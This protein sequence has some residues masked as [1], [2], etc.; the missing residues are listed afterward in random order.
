MSM[1]TALQV[2]TASN[3]WEP[4]RR[5]TL[6]SARRRSVV[7]RILRVTFVSA[8][9]SIIGLVA[10]YVIYNTK[11]PEPAP[12]VAQVQDIDPGKMLIV[13]PVYTGRDESNGQY[14]V[15][16]ETAATLS[17]EETITELVR[18]QLGRGDD[19]NVTAARGVYDDQNK[20][21]ELF[22]EVQLQTSGGFVF[23]TSTAKIDIKKDRIVGEEAVEG[24]GPMGDI[25]ADGYEILNGGERVVFRGRVTTS[26]PMNSKKKDDGDE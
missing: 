19:P 3:G 5:L 18:P 24:T 12:P 11:N 20:T 22:D 10:S 25:K 15:K 16:A 1:D 8:A 23:D 4:S 21:L 2:N 13:N 6:T 26:I 17:E 9:L 14:V 7:V